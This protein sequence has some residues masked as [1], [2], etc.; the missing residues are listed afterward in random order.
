MNDSIDNRY[1]LALF[2]LA[3][4]DNKVNEY[5][6]EIKNINKI[7]NENVDF[8]NLLKSEFVSVNKR[9]EVIDKV[10]S[11]YSST[12]K[13]FIKILIQN[14]RLNNYKSIF[15]SFNSLCNEENNVMEGIIYSTEV[16]SEDKINT[17]AMALS[18]KNNNRVELINKIDKG[19]IGG[20]KVV[21]NNHIYDY[22]IN[23][24]LNNM[25][26]KLNRR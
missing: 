23:S 8:L 6:I 12:S 21:I 16:L 26:L 20:V 4:E 17:I 5:Q 3:K 1:A 18:K 14:H 11:N 19:L 7:F 25:R 2:S 13:N 9:Y 15:T 10:L 22:S 24:E